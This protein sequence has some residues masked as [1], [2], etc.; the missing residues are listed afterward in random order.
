MTNGTIEWTGP[1]RWNAVRGCTRENEAC[2]NCYA[3]QLAGLRFSGHDENG[4]PLPF[5]GFATR[6]IRPDGKAEGRWTGKVELIEEKLTEPLRWRKPQLCFANST[7]DIFHPSLSD[8]DIDRLFAVA[9]L[10][11]KHHFQ[12]LTKRW[13]RMGEYMSRPGVQVR[14]GLEALGITMEILARNPKSKIGKGI[15]IKGSD[16]N[17]GALMKWTL[18]NVS[19]GV[20]AHDQESANAAIPALLSTPAALR[21]VSYEPALGGVDWGN[22]FDSRSGRLIDALSGEWQ[23]N[24]VDQGDRYVAINSNYGDG[25]KIDLIIAGD[26]SGEG[27]RPADPNW[28]RQTRDQCAAAGVPFFLK[29]M[30]VDGKLQSTPE[31]DGHRHTD[32]PEAWRSLL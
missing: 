10:S 26:E 12:L 8:T 14:I 1:K 4:K 2:R 21:F 27:K 30:H 22:I 3:E 23:D 11:A 25:P 9:A 29:Q 18:P 19:L 32:L 6:V 5:H 24:V 28:Y 15:L 20:S 7:F 31:L 16:I 17:P 13:D